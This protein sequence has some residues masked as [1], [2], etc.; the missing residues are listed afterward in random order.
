MKRAAPDL[1]TVFAT[2]PARSCPYGKEVRIHTYSEVYN[3]YI[4]LK[5]HNKPIFSGQKQRISSHIC[6]IPD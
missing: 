2:L 6:R 4:S 3:K 1:V 5:W